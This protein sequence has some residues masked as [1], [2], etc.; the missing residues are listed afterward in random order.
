MSAGG[1]SCP[2]QRGNSAGWFVSTAAGKGF[3]YPSDASVAMATVD[4]RNKSGI[5]SFGVCP[6]WPG[7][8]GA[9]GDTVVM[10]RTMYLVIMA[11]L[12]ILPR[13]CFGPH[14]S[15]GAADCFSSMHFSPLVYAARSA[16]DLTLQCR[17]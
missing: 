7:R 2:Q 16:S 17:T 6:S 8:V 11:L 10:S 1:G 9:S 4:K 5:L 12:N 13:E 3:L 14:L 15:S